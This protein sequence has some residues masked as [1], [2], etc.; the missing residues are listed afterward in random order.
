MKISPSRLLPALASALA[1]TLCAGAATA[2]D[3]PVKS[4][5]KIAFLGDSITAMGTGPTGYVTLVV[6]GLKANG[7]EVTP[8]GAGHSGDTS[9]NMLSRLGPHVIDQKPDWMT[10]SCG[11]NDVNN[12][13][14]GVPLDKFKEN[15]TRIVDK[16]QAA[17][18]KVI[19]LTATPI[20]EDLSSPKNQT[21]ADYNAFLTAL[22]AEK[23]CL[24]ADLNAD[25]AKILQKGPKKEKMLLADGLHP[26][27]EGNR[28]MAIGILR[29]LGLSDEQMTRAEKAWA[30]LPPPAPRKPAPA[31]K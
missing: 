25:F 18:I 22:A 11:V 6:A 12:P 24:L 17:G 10:L 7:I 5:E 30:E 3:I 19:L 20:G 26:H 2:A 8:I 14:F 1:M 29:T 28:V 21:L 4:G 9:G 23:H 13:R 27:K 16:A 31:A 15:V